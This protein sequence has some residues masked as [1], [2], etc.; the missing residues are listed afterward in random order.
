MRLTAERF[1]GTP[2]DAPVGA[3]SGVE[4]AEQVPTVSGNSA[5]AVQGTPASPGGTLPA[6]PATPPATDGTQPPASSGTTPT[7]T[8]PLPGDNPLK[9]CPIYG[10]F[11][12]SADFGAPR[13]SGG[14]HLH[15][16]NDIFA[17]LGTPVVA[18]FDGIA[19][20]ARNGLGGY[21]V[22]VL[23]AQGYVYNAHLAAYGLLGPVTAGTVIGFVG[24]SGNA[25]ATPPHNH[26]EWHPANGEAIDPFTL[27]AGVCEAA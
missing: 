27:L 25:E 20:D 15:Q 21:A 19:V 5:P 9:V 13:Y 18:P 8:I 3:S 24:N 14:F 16:G 17:P 12:F 23:G 11:S 6:T 26:F 2:G 22:K 4:Q 7:G 10:P 1:W